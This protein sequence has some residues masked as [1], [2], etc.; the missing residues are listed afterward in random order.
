MADDAQ[1]PEPTGGN[2]IQPKPGDK[3]VTT[4]TAPRHMKFVR[5]S[6]E[7]LDDLRSSN[8]TLSLAFFNS[9]FGALITVV[10]TLLTV[11]ISDPTT[12][13]TFRALAVLFLI[14][15]SYFGVGAIQGER[16]WRTKIDSLKNS[17]ND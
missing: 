15:S 3:G 12:L 17:S 1:V 16:R 8:S 4:E 11:H 13:A 2:W 10:A 9:S 14:T 7:E 5:V 6:P